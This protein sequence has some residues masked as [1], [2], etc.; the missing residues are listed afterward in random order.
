[1]HR[2]RFC[3]LFF[4]LLV[5]GCAPEDLEEP[6]LRSWAAD[7]PLGGGDV[8]VG[9]LQIL[10]ADGLDGTSTLI[11]RVVVDGQ[12]VVLDFGDERTT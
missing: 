4:A 10:V 6:V 3:R 2:R 12:P 1:M 9:P 7:V 11:H 5:V 8:V